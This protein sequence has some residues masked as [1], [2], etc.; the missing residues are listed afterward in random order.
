MASPD[1]CTTAVCCVVLNSRELLQER[2]EPFS[3]QTPRGKRHR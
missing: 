2:E 3:L 1:V